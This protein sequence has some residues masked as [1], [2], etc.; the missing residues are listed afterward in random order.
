MKL[1]PRDIA[2][3]W[4]KVDRRG[5][6]ECWEWREGTYQFGYGHFWVDS[7]SQGAH[8]IAWILFN[9]E[10]PEGLFVLHGCDN[11][12]CCNPFHLRVGDYQDNANDMVAR[13]RSLS[14]DR[15]PIHK[16]NWTRRGSEVTNSKLKESDI[17]EIRRMR[18]GGA[19]LKE[20]AAKF[21]VSVSSIHLIVK[22]R[23]W[24]HV[25]AEAA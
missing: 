24:K 17:I 11:P 15:H 14:G 2:R 21:N 10:V 20:I 13:G 8:R 6:D 1:T 19:L 23:N 16:Y 9:G 22:G 18:A 4:S 3:F 25:S 5:P 7:E 12:P